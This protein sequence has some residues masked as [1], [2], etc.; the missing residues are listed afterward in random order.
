MLPTTF[1]RAVASRLAMPRPAGTAQTTTPRNNTLHTLATYRPQL[2]VNI[3]KSGNRFG[4]SQIRANKPFS[5]SYAEHWGLGRAAPLVH[6]LTQENTE[7]RQCNEE[8]KLLNDKSVLML[9]DSNL[10]MEKSNLLMGESIL[11]IEE[12]AARERTANRIS[13]WAL[14][15]GGFGICSAVYFWQFPSVQKQKE[16]LEKRGTS[17]LMLVW[18]REEGEMIAALF[19]SSAP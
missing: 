13:F 6:G 4:P 15:F 12:L 17:T 2:N 7:L 8:L 16:T 3:N 5:R 18:E 10:L 9:D 14:L 11:L 1:R 19:M